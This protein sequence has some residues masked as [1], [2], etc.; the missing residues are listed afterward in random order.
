[1]KRYEV[2]MTEIREYRVKVRVSADNADEAL[3]IAATVAL[4]ED[5]K[6]EELMKTHSRDIET[7][8]EVNGPSGKFWKD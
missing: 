5:S 8:E 2:T 3:D 4:S 6:Q 1:M 7:V